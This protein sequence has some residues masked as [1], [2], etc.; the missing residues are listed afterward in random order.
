MLAL[1]IL[2]VSLVAAGGVFAYEKYLSGESAS[3]GAELAKDEQSVSQNTV[4]QFVELQN[5]LSSATGLLDTHVTLT[6]FF[7]IL[8]SLTLS[9]VQYTSLK[10]TVNDDRTADLDAT[11]VASTFNALAAESKA[12]SSSP[13]IERAVFSNFVTQK[14]GGVSFSL[15]ATVDA[16]AVAALGTATSSA[17]HAATSTPAAPQQSGTAPT[18]TTTTTTKPPTT[19]GTV[20][21]TTSAVQAP[22][23]SAGTAKTTTS[24]PTAP[25]LPTP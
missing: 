25:P 15:T 6:N 9:H 20:P 16:G 2:G 3:K 11:G 5:R 22:P 10:L 7:N 14:N 17:L 12:F 8:E 18:N 19:T 21:P 4:Q 1:F 13:Q 23:T 24:G